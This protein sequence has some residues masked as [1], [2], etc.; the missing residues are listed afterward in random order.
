MFY[1]PILPGGRL[2]RHC[3]QGL[4]RLVL[5]LVAL[6]T[7]GPARAQ[8]PLVLA[9]DD[10][11]P[12]KTHSGDT[13]GGAYTEIVRELALRVGLPLTIKPCPLKRCLTMLQHGDADIIIGVKDTPER[14]RYLH[15]LHT[16]YRTS[17]ADK[18]FFVLKEKGATV[19][20]YADL[21]PLRI[22]VKLGAEY[23]ARFDQDAALKK[24][25]SK[26]MDVNFRKLAMGRLDAVIAA[27]DQGEAML[28]QLQ[29]GGKIGKAPFRVPDPSARSI[30][31]A[32]HSKHMNKLAAFDK[33]MAAMAKDG[34][35]AALY[36]RYYYDAYRVPLDAVQVR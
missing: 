23:F 9:F 26:D 15:F 5:L 11:L 14:Q 6:A 22:G 3:H 32:R 31:I 12:W 2:G 21:S 35:L 8:A 16:P 17:S 30:A 20:S 19:K 36:R 4:L 28:A 1:L 27:E 25:T 10:L 33:A 29:L 24:D 13:Y 7:T 34:T 18:V